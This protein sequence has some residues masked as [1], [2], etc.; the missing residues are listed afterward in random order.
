MHAHKMT[1]MVPESG[2]IEH[3]I[4]LP[5]DFHDLEAVEAG[6]G[7]SS[8]FKRAGYPEET[9]TIA[10]KTKTRADGGAHL[11]FRRDEPSGRKLFCI[12][13]SPPASAGLARPRIPRTAS[14]ACPSVYAT[15]FSAGCHEL[16]C[17]LVIHQCRLAENRGLRQSKLRQVSMEG[18]VQRDATRL[19]E[20]GGHERARGAKR[21]V[22][23]AIDSFLAFA[24]RFTPVDPGC[25]PGRVLYKLPAGFV[26][27][28]LPNGGR[29][30]AIESG[31][32]LLYG[33]EP[34]AAGV[35]TDGLQVWLQAATVP[36]RSV[37]PAAARIDSAERNKIE[38]L[39]LLPW[40]I[41]I[42]CPWLRSPEHVEAQESFIHVDLHR[43]RRR[44]F[45]HRHTL[46]SCLLV[47]APAS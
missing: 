44:V 1:V 10:H 3:K 30:D 45:Q 19:T 17:D 7:S 42:G 47:T 26:A 37:A 5:A 13:C 40:H 24:D 25:L 4:D 20:R 36:E 46:A 29:I 31:G 41:R 16:F 32:E 23:E 33:A 43:K 22:A 14:P 8:V 34:R 18:I 9:G 39:V 15:R 11:H 38:G 6:N 28:H 2:H 27:E 12:V 35:W 21:E